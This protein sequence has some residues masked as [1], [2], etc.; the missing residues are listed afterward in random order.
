MQR[1]HNQRQRTSWQPVAGESIRRRLSLQHRVPSN[2]MH[3]LRQRSSR[4]HRRAR[5]SAIVAQGSA[6][7]ASRPNSIEKLSNDLRA[8]RMPSSRLTVC[9]FAHSQTKASVDIGV[10]GDFRILCADFRLPHG[11]VRPSSALI[12]FLIAQLGVLRAQSRAK[13][14]LSDKTTRFK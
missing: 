3:E 4:C 5:T 14:A 13:G 6:S 2:T 1:V 7:R 10:S 8:H 9:V 11:V 12:D